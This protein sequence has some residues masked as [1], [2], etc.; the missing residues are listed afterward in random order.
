M[1]KGGGGE[2]AGPAAYHEIRYQ[3]GWH[4]HTALVTI[5]RPREHNSYTLTT[6]K[7]LISAF[8]AAMWDDDVQ[9]I[10]LTGSGDKPSTF[11]QNIT[12]SFPLMIYGKTFFQARYASKTWHFHGSRYPIRD[13][14]SINFL[15]DFF[16]TIPLR[17]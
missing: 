3:T 2:S 13:I 5:D 9:F 17:K 1:R 16:L 7:E 12:D 4:D 10:V 15:F 6:L 8:D 11:F 14:R